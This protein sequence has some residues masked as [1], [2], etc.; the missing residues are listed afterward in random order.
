MSIVSATDLVMRSYLPARGVSAPHLILCP[1]AGA[2]S[3]GFAG[4]RSIGELNLRMSLVVYP[5]RDHRMGEPA[6]TSISIL[7]QE[8]ADMIA[9]MSADEREMVILAGHSMGAQVAFEACLRLEERGLPPTG[10]LLSG[11]H[12]PHLKSRRMLSHLDNKRFIKEL[13]S[14][15]G[16]DPAVEADPNILMPFLPLL[17]SDFLATE[18]YYRKLVEPR[19]RLTTPALLMS[20]THDMEVTL[21]EVAAWSL[22]LDLVPDICEIYGDHFYV[23]QRPRAFASAVIKFFNRQRIR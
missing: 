1:F 21:N 2:S 16:C 9:S 5:G 3:S 7:S 15:G 13:I 22:W 8:I 18:T 6:A 19:S 10:L 11:C 20:G 23:T 17:R 14:I 4:W 12:P